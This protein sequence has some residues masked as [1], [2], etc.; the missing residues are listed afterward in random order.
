MPGVQRHELACE[1]TIKQ[2]TAVMMTEMIQNLAFAK[3]HGE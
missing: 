3:V 2:T 1:S